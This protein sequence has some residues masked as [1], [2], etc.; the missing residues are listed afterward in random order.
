MKYRVLLRP[1]PQL[2]AELDNISLLGIEEILKRTTVAA[3]Q[4]NKQ[5]LL[6]EGDQE[7]AC[8]TL[9]SAWHRLPWG[10]LAQSLFA[11]KES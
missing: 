9:W 2:A 6:Q 4:R 5:H 1:T 8:S 3:T 10:L 7:K 11:S